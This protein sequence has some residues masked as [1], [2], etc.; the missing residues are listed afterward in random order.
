[1]TATAINLSVPGGDNLNQAF[2]KVND[3]F[4]DTL[5]EIQMGTAVGWNTVITGASQAI[6]VTHSKGDEW[7]KETYTYGSGSTT[8]LVTE[9]LYEQSVNG[10]VDWTTKGTVTI[11]YD[12]SGNAINTTWS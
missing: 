7:V 9:V 3:G 4:L 2:T 10:G 11:T 8:G 6:S 12:G 5:R 1:M